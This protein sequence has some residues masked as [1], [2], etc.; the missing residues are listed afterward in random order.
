MINFPNG[1]TT[2]PL[3]GDLLV[4][5]RA[6]LKTGHIAVISRVNTKMQTIDVLEENFNNEKW[7]GNYARRIN[8]SKRHG[9]YWILDGYLLGWKHITK[10]PYSSTAK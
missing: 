8:Y 10:Q 3:A 2:K 4:Y 1:S 9:H 6:Y 5:A 7:P